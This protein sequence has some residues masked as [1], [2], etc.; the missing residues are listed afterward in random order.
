MVAVRHNEP[1]RRG[2]RISSL[3]AIALAAGALSACSSI[4][5]T[6]TSLKGMF[7]GGSSSD[8]AATASA[9]SPSAPRI[10][11]DDCPG[12]E[13][14]PGAGALNVT[15][16]KV[17]NGIT[18]QRYQLSF[19]SLARECHVLAGTMTIKLGIEGRIILGPAGGPGKVDVP[20]RYAVVQEGPDPK[21]VTTNFDPFSV[22]VEPGETN[23]TFV[24]VVEAINFPLP[25]LGD[26]AAYVVY[27]GFDAQAT[28]VK[29]AKPS[30]KRR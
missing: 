1:A 13:I 14:R 19:N 6:T 30:K 20:F 12:V 23:K 2:A 18:G 26:L 29:P 28:P 5:S 25:P 4:S 22:T 27:V 8:Q 24:H 3:L 17:A 11:D 9:S 16:P 10:T 15:D 21:T 7:G